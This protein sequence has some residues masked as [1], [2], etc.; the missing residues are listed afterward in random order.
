ML[1]RPIVAES[2]LVMQSILDS[3]QNEVGE[4]RLKARN[5]K[6]GS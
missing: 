3:I 2:F 5:A 4:A 6:R 1:W